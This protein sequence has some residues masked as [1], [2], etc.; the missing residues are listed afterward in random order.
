MF[1]RPVFHETV[2][3]LPVPPFK[4]LDALAAAG[5]VG[6]YDLSEDYPELGNALLVCATETKTDQDIVYYA[7]Q[8]RGLL[9]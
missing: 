1:D 3:S 7:E 6:G 8:L 2:L 9:Q 5:I 4:A